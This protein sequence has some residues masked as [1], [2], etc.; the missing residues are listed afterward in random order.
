M[1]PDP[2]PNWW[3]EHLEV[4]DKL[5][6]VDNLDPCIQAFLGAAASTH[7]AMFAAP[8]FVTSG[9]DAVHGTGS[10]HYA[11]KAVDIR[12]RDLSLLDANRFAQAMVPLQ[13][14]MKVG[15]FDERFIGSPHWHV[16]TA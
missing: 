15:I 14:T 10:K 6:E 7:W 5:V 13:A 8:L 11:W 2:V 3:P 4:A 12:S 9:H 16:E 1:I